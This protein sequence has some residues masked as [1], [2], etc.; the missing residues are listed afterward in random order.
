MFPDLFTQ[1]IETASEPDQRVKFAFV[2]LSVYI[3]LI[4]INML[5]QDLSDEQIVVTDVME[6]HNSALQIYRT[7]GNDRWFNIL[8]W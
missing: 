7:L 6:S 8:R 5:Q 3:D 1:P 4:L 2:P